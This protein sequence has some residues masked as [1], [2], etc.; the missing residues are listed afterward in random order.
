MFT[1]TRAHSKG[2][3]LIFRGHTKKPLRVNLEHKKIRFLKKYY[4]VRLRNGYINTLARGTTLW[5]LWLFAIPIF[6]VIYRTGQSDKNQAAPR[7][8]S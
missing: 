1:R 2:I 3:R 7:A 5:L 6:Y 4:I 8:T